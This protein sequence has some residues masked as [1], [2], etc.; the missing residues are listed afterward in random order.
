MVNEYWEKLLNFIQPLLDNITI[1]ALP[2]V[3]TLVSCAIAAV[4][5]SLVIVGSFGLLFAIASEAIS[6]QT[7]RGFFA[8]TARQIAQ[9][10][11]T[12]G[13]IAAALVGGGFAWAVTK[14]PALL[15]DTNLLAEPYLLPLAV[16]GGSIL[17]AV[18]LLAVYLFIRPNKGLAGKGH[19]AFG[20]LSGLCAAFSLFCF[21]GVVRRL[22]HT[23]PDFDIS[24]PWMTKLVL[25]FSIPADSFFWPLLIQSVPLGL[26]LAAAFA[27]I[28]LLLMREKQ[29]YGRDYYA[30]ALPYCARWA[31]GFTLLAVCAGV[32][33][34]YRSRALMLPELSCE[35]SL[36]LDCLTA[37][38]PLLA[39]LIWILVAR[40]AHP[41]RH[42]ISVVLAGLFLLTGFT[43]QVLMLNTII[44][45]P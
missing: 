35:P 11:L 10:T 26:A 17:F 24:L 9:M 38:L 36:F 28:W 41:M 13:I 27:C 19:L 22:L 33:V 12:V 43:G 2:P 30:F 40:S 31:A 6:I 34:F 15:Q 44:P 16:A 14:D 29:D 18:L 42:K 3:E 4:L 8:R 25:F 21:I 23:P 37:G 45:S 20:F 1:P 39:C 7:K 5:V 32:F